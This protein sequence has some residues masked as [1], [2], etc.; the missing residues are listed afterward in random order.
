VRLIMKIEW[1][2]AV[3]S[4]DWRCNWRLRLS[5]VRDAQGCHERASSEIQLD[6]GIVQLRDAL[7]GHGRT[8]LEMLSEAEIG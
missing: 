8:C 2:E 3:I 4:R 1:T 6:A 7:G 5:E